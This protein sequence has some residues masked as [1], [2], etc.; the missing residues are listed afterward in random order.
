[1]GGPPLGMDTPG[2]W[3]ICEVELGS[4]WTL[5]LYSDGLY[6]GGVSGDGARLGLEAF[7]ELLSERAE[8]G[9]LWSELPELLIA[10]VESLNN[11]PLDDDVAL[12]ALRFDGD[13]D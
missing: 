7:V 5:L 13:L 1:V 6:E 10:H 9:T 3:E 12:L 8:R 4:Q 2:K 11:G